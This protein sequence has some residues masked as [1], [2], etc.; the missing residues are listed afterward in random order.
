VDAVNFLIETKRQQDKLDLP[1]PHDYLADLAAFLRRRS[2]R[3]VLLGEV[4]LPYPDLMQFFGVRDGGGSTDELTMCFDFIGMQAM[5]LSLARGDAGPLVDALKQ[6]PEPPE[7]GHWATFV[8]NH[9][10]LTLDKL[11][12]AQRQ[13]VFSRV[14]ARRGHA[15]LRARDPQ[16]AAADARR[17]PA[18][19]PAW[20]TACSSRCRAPGALLRRGDR[21][22]RQPRERGPAGRRVPDAVDRPVRG[23]G[24]STAGPVTFPEPPAEG[25]FSASTSTSATSRATP[26]RCCRSSAPR[27]ARTGRARSSR[28]A[29]HR[30]STPARTAAPVL[31]HRADVDGVAIVAVHNFADRRSPP[32]SR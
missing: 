31:A 27:R 6:R 25:A 32:R 26:A 28:G 19:D 30:C 3:P 13:E 22:G 2:G 15:A 9:D 5:Y 29:R 21:P 16:A 1:D 24:F 4:N 8:R 7:D 23:G 10:E 11:T 12:D 18:P 17:R 20:S 14:R